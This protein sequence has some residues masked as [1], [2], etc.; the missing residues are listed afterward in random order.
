MLHDLGMDP[1]LPKMR[2][3]PWRADVIVLFDWLRW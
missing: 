1:S 3:E 2:L